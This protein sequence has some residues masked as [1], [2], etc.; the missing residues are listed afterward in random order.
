MATSVP[1][2]MANI[3]CSACGRVHTDD[4]YTRCVECGALL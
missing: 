3:R 1:V 4:E 2:E